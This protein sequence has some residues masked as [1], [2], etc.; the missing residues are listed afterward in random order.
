MIFIKI[1]NEQCVNS[2]SACPLRKTML[3]KDVSDSDMPSILKKTF[4]VSFN[5]SK[6]SELSKKL[7]FQVNRITDDKISNNQNE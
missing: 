5:D 2:H 1:R 3:H 6:K 4:D 7:I